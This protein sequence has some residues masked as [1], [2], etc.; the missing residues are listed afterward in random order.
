MIMK[1]SISIISS[2]LLFCN[3]ITFAG[4][5][6][7]MMKLAEFAYA[8]GD[9]K[10][11]RNYY[12]EI[13][14]L[15]SV[16]HEQKSVAQH[17][18]NL[19]NLRILEIE[20][21]KGYNQAYT[22]FKN[23]NYKTCRSHCLYLLK[24]SKHIAK[25]KHLIAQCDAALSAQLR[26]AQIAD[27]IR[28]IQTQLRDEYDFWL[29]K[30][31]SYYNNKEFEAA[32]ACYNYS[33]EYK[34]SSVAHLQQPKWLGRCDSIIAYKR[35]GG[36]VVNRKLAQTI[37]NATY[38][39]DFSEGFAYIELIDSTNN[40]NK[41]I[42]NTEGDIICKAY[43]ILQ[44]CHDGYFAVNGHGGF[45]DTS[46]NWSRRLE[47]QG[48]FLCNCDRF[49]EGMAPIMNNKNKWGYVDKNLNIIIAPKYDYVTAFNEGMALVRKGS[50]W[51]YIDNVGNTIIKSFNPGKDNYENGYKDKN[52][53]A[54]FSSGIS[55][56]WNN[57]EDGVVGINKKGDICLRG[58]S[59]GLYLVRDKLNFWPHY[60][61]GLCPI[62]ELLG[63][64]KC[65]FGF[66]DITGKQIIPPIYD[67]VNVF[68]ENFAVVMKEGLTGIINTKGEVV[69]PL[70]NRLFGDYYVSEGLIPVISNKLYGF[71]NLE[72][73]LI[74]PFQFKHAKSFHCGLAV[75]K[76]SNNDNEGQYGYVDIWGNSTFDFK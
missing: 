51:F 11:A 27:S 35:E 28:L 25:T 45:I 33:L 1:K 73:K 31:N 6:Q 4:P 70:S 14:Q 74:I 2:I 23:G 44:D 52:G 19:C 64:G 59:F 46:G 32:R 42:I 67:E 40:K 39:S 12:I 22:L 13:T 71:L 48:F 7:E 30:A 57:K 68:K 47:E 60:S 62:G 76:S 72:N 37:S 69:I 3:V 75:V 56:I 26:N 17:N 18:I 41:Y 34:Y 10:K 16:T 15:S 38:L 8:S 49:T 50:K 21:N 29:D 5:V 66:I 20:Y 24:Y 55:W 54:F 65:K 9:Y 58:F 36:V 53:N 61:N 43:S 63:P